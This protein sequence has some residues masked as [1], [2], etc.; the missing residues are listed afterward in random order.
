MPPGSR[1]P[2]GAASG[3]RPH[4]ASNAFFSGQMEASEASFRPSVPHPGDRAAFGLPRHARALPGCAKAASMS[5]PHDA[6]AR[7]RRAGRNG[8]RRANNYRRSYS[9]QETREGRGRWR[10]DQA[11]KALGGRDVAARA[12]IRRAPTNDAPLTHRSVRRARAR[13]PRRATGEAL[14]RQ[15]TRQSQ[16]SQP[17]RGPRRCE[18][19]R[20]IPNLPC[21]CSHE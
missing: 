8:T 13:K 3:C 7:G 15:R 20:R 2:S 5:A 12:G 1:V 4:E 16:P 11:L 21:P 17:V 18:K 10:S 19:H 14:L 6:P 9:A